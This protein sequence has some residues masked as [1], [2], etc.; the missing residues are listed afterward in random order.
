M[1]TVWIETIGRVQ[2]TLL[3]RYEDGDVRVS[4]QGYTYI[5]KEIA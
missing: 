3:Q 1:I 2:A 4:Y 5:A